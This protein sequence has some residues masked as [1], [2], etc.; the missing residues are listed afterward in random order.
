MFYIWHLVDCIKVYIFIDF[1]N[2]IVYKLFYFSKIIFFKQV[3]STDIVGLLHRLG[4]YPMDSQWLL[5][6]YSI[7]SS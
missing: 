1:Q 6:M 7:D 5:A 4:Y 3:S 2:K